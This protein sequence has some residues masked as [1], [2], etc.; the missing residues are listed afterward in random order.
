MLARVPTRAAAP[1]IVHL[2]IA[3]SARSF[4]LSSLESGEA[5][6]PWPKMGLRRERFLSGCDFGAHGGEVVTFIATSF[7]RLDGACDPPMF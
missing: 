1:G 3:Q 5:A 4:D 7:R 2:L 6:P